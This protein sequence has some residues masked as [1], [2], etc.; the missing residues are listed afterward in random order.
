MGCRW[1]TGMDEWIVGWFGGCVYVFRLCMYSFIHL[2]YF[3]SA[4]S[5]LPL[6]RGAPNTAL[7]LCRN[8]RRSATATVS[9][10]LVQVPYVVARPGVEPMTLRTKGVNSTN[11]PYMHCL[12]HCDS[13]H[14]A[15]CISS[16]LSLSHCTYHSAS[17]SYS[18]S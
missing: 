5:S 11:A 4:S 8:S 6:L 18:S 2:G 16:F 15:V 13:V 10:G 1:I 17:V 12:S 9:E 7:I 3:Y 14:L